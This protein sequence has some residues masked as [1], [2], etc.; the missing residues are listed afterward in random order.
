MR[1]IKKIA[2]F[3]FDLENGKRQNYL[4]LHYETFGRPLGTA[5]V[6][7]INHSLTGNS[8]VSGEHGWWKE[9]IGDQK[10]IDTELFT[11]LSFNIPGN[12]YGNPETN[13]IEN[14][15]DF[16]VRDIACLFWEGLHF[17]DVTDIYS[18]I[19]VSLGGTIA[20]EMAALQPDK[21]E[22]LIPIATHWKATDW[23][24][25]NV[26][27]QDQILN[28]SNNP[29]VDARMHATLLYHSP[30][31]ISQLYKG[32]K[33]D[34]DFSFK[35]EEWLSDKGSQLKNRYQLTAYKFM[36]H[37]LKTNDVTRNR[38]DITAIARDIESNIHL[39]SV[40]TDYLF[41]TEECFKTFQKIRNV[42]QNIYYNLIESTYGHDAFLIDFEAIAKILSPILSNQKKE[43]YAY[44]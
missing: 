42:K 21:I 10:A 20:W 25:A 1:N 13:L 38:K 22:H 6:I 34:N 19:G 23:V 43:N 5:P 15:Q 7:V 40:D 11:V 14:Y 16:T 28:N 44:S 26:L 37:L 17:L 30:E 8:T 4:L 18:L 9:I 3:D 24:I 33:L 12:G 29:L 31:Y 36:N 32:E 39:V 2:F 35:I 27:I 41:T